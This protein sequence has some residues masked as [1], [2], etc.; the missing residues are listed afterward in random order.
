[1]KSKRRHVSGHRRFCGS[2]KS[3]SIEEC[4]EVKKLFSDCMKTDK[5]P[6][7]EEIQTIKI[8][9]DVLQARSPQAIRMWIENQ[10][11]KKRKT[12][13]QSSDR[14][15]VVKRIRWSDIEKKSLYEAFS[16]HIHGD[17]LPSQSEVL[18]G[19]EKFPEL[20][21]R[22]VKCIKTAVLNE[23]NRSKRGSCM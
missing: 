5:L 7:Y 3:W 19:I 14:A 12:S 15:S 10:L 4:S 6:S 18:L 16:V 8:N 1:M 20:K 11:L 9:N 23:K 22:S 13:D 17:T 21:S 2:K